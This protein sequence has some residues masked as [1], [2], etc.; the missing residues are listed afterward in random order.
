MSSI[1]RKCVTCEYICTCKCKYCDNIICELCDDICL[2][3][4]VYVDNINTHIKNII[5]ELIKC[6][7]LNFVCDKLCIVNKYVTDTNELLLFLSIKNCGIS[8]ID[9]LKSFSFEEVKNACNFTNTEILILKDEY[10]L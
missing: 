5:P 10:M 8:V 6:F 1:N 7:G 9:I 4:S 3:C 2:S